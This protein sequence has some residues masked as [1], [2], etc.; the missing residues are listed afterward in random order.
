MLLVFCGNMYSQKKKKVVKKEPASQIIAKSNDLTAEIIKTDFFLFR[1]EKGA[2]KDTLLLKTFAEKVTPTE[3]VITPF[4]AK[5]IPLYCITWKENKITETKVKKEDATISNAQIWNPATK[6]QIHSNVQTIKKIKEQV[7]LDRLKTAS[8]TQEKIQ[9]DGY[10]FTLLPDGDFTLKG[11]TS[12]TKYTLNITSM[13]YE[14]P[15]KT[16]SSPYKKKK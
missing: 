14:I 6:L 13:K 9:K 10:V 7:F 11:K 4:V 12:D 15:L 5:G 8:E 16:N 1:N 3:C 2:K